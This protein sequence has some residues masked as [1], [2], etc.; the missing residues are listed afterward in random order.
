[1]GL[2]LKFGEPAFNLALLQLCV[3]MRDAGI[4]PGTVFDVGANIGQFALAATTIF[5]DA[6]IYSY[7]PIGSAY[8]QLKV[9]AQRHGRIHPKNNALGRTRGT[10]K[11]HITSQTTSSSLLKLGERHR[12]AYPDIVEASQQ[13]VSVTTLSDEVAAQTLNAP[14]LLKLD[15]QGFESEV[16]H[17]A[18][19]ALRQFRWVLLETSTSPMYEG[20]VLFDAITAFLQ[21]SGFRFVSPLDI[22]FA[23]N[24]GCFGQFDALYERTDDP[25]Q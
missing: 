25:G 1:M 24:S 11:I 14:M 22:H 3:R 18:G 2:R 21:K 16:L 10:A 8:A 15:V 23:P 19:D 17:G 6:T 12:H 4:V 7:E 9:L 20:E 5:P 13:E